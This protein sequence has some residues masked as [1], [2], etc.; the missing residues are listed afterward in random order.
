MKARKS[1][2]PNEID[3][4]EWGDLEQRP[5]DFPVALHDRA[6]CCWDAARFIGEIARKRNMPGDTNIP[7]AR[8]RLC[9]HHAGI[10]HE[11]DPSAGVYPIGRPAA[12][13]AHPC[14]EEP[15]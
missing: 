11:R 9:A 8:F 13:I 15:A 3:W 4:E 7:P 10:L 1:M 2:N 14:M 5:R 6:D 12:M